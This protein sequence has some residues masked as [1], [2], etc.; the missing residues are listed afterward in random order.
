MGIH[1]QL[2][3]VEWRFGDESFPFSADFVLSRLTTTRRSQSL[4]RDCLHYGILEIEASNC[5]ID[6]N[7]DDHDHVLLG[8]D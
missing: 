1:I 4:L 2:Q 7:H 5:V 6:L 3:L 8:T